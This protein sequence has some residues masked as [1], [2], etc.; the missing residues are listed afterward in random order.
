MSAANWKNVNNWH[1]TDK[2]CFDWAKS[3][4]EQT[5]A[6]LE[7]TSGDKTVKIAK[8]TS[9]SGD[10]DLN[11]RKG[12]V[13]ALYDVELA[14]KWVGTV[15]GKEDEYSGTITVPEIAHDTEREDFV[16]DTRLDAVDKSNENLDAQTGNELKELVRKQLSSKLADEFLK[17]H[18]ALIS[19]NLGD[20]YIK[21]SDDPNSTTSSAGN[22]RT[23]PKIILNKNSISSEPE[24]VKAFKAGKSGLNLDSLSGG[25]SISTGKITMDIE[26]KA[27]PKD[28]FDALT[29][30]STASLWSRS[31]ATVSSSPNSNFELFGG[32]V[33]GTVIKAEQSKDSA[34]TFVIVQKWRLG[35]WPSNHFSTVEMT[36]T[37]GSNST[38]LGLVQTGVPSNELEVTERNW[39]HYYWDPIKATFGWGFHV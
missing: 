7:L 30:P 12:K 33:S 36:I 4:F 16:F 13:M 28:V 38:K 35:Q 31:S 10:V 8:V 5:L 21:A 17:F 24:H 34:N 3:Y 25:Y 14:L 18:E 37:E 32:N 2:N 29:N 1:W 19:N 11:Q 6:N 9:V 26:F 23:E 22:I 20:V 15:A 27:P 39:T